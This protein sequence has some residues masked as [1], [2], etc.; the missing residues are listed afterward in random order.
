MAA[1]A[2]SDLAAL[3]PSDE[4]YAT[5]RLDLPAIPKTNDNFPRRDGYF[6]RTYMTRYVIP[7]GGEA[8]PGE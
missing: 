2:G 4:A 3:P 7:S 5:A 6:Y 8:G 1:L